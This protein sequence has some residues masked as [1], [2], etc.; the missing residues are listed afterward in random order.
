M[1]AAVWYGKEDVRVEDV[2]EPTPTEGEVI[3]Q[4]ERTG[5]CGTDLHEYLAGPLVASPGTIMGHEFSGTVVETG[6]GVTGFRSGQRVAGIGVT[7]D[8]TCWYCRHGLPG[9]CENPTF[10]GLRRPGALA[11]RVSVP[12]SALFEIPDDLSLVDA[13]L[14]EPLGVAFHAVRRSGLSVGETVY[15]AGAGPIGLGV[16]QSARAAGASE[17]IVSEVSPRRR[18]AAEQLGATRVIDPTSEDPVEVAR[19]LTFGRGADVGFDTAGVQVAF[20]P[21][22]Q[23][24]RKRGRFVVVA[25]WEKPANIPLTDPLLREIELKFTFCYEADEEIPQ[26]IKL[27]ARG[28]IK[29]APMISSQIPLG[30]IVTSG[31]E[32]LRNHRD[33]Q[34]KILVNPSA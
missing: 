34:V 2:P 8:G 9:L 30:E 16:L 20:D 25:E 7:G 18:A 4:I 6:P 12:A 27:I 13:A 11:P 5:I 19:S 1:R 21:A 15:I 24:I 14:V 31:F 23:A 17:I 32:E 33:A 22:L 28:D 29:T 3:L 26:L 10:I